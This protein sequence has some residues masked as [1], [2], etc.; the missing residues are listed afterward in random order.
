MTK[1]LIIEDQEAMKHLLIRQIEIMGFVAV[2]ANNAEDGVKAATVEKPD[3]I[4]MDLMMP[5]IDG[6]KV[7]RMLRAHPETQGVPI[8]ATSALSRK[9]DVEACMEA[10]CTDSIAKPFT[11][12][13]LE[14]KIR[15]LITS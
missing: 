14:I 9:S 3:L 13:E 7:T 6:L 1:I 8:L 4:L 12:E 2:S 15:K 5:K 11:F 10:G